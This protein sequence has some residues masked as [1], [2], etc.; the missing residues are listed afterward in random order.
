MRRAL[1]GVGALL[2]LILLV[3]VLQIA[4]SESGEVVVL[5]TQDANDAAHETR[6][7]VVEH[8][9]R[10]WLRAGNPGTGWLVRL[11]AR[12]EVEIVRGGETLRVRAVPVPD[13]RDRIN[14]LMNEKYGLADS[15]VCLFFRRPSKIPVRLDA[16]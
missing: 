11:Q 7:W 4:A 12:P 14:A 6:L 5:R 10:P 16:R 9:G 3:F 1:R 13:A 15:Y 2:A 8:E